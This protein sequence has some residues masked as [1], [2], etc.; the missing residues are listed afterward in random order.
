MNEVSIKAMGGLK[1]VKE[2]ESIGQ[3]TNA[4]TS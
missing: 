1:R 3:G 2:F 4:R